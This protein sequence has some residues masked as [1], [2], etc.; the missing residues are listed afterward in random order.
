MPKNISIK[1]KLLSA[2]CLTAL[3]GLFLL[4]TAVI[5]MER[6]NATHNLINELSTM[7]DVVAW[8]SS[9]AMMFDDEKG[10]GE[11]LGSLS[12]KPEIAFACLFDTRGKKYRDYTRP[13]NLPANP[14]EGFLEGLPEGTSITERLKVEGSIVDRN[15]RYIRV[16]RPV[17][18]NDMLLGSIL[19]VDD[20]TQLHDLLRRY[21]ILLA[22]AV[23]TTL[24]VVFIVS[25]W[26]Q[27]L[28]T[29]PMTR[30]IRTMAT[31]TRDKVYEIRAEKQNDDEFGELFD[32]FNEMIR[33]VRARDR[34][35]KAHSAGLEKRVEQRT[36][37]LS[38]A[39]PSWRQAWPS[40]RSQ[41]MRR[42][43][44]AGPNPS[45]WPI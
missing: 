20:L 4:S 7:A 33:E 24:V 19:L 29:A 13:G 35:L 45:F 27:R 1:I 39:K 28:F 26:S 16:I 22:I 3:L 21:S 14:E 15:A 31:V 38:L 5:I 9:V 43:K 34:E 37:D 18:D 17:F 44:P 30:L 12:R 10:A 42:R 25:S 40:L 6:K 2:F 32:H 23:F 11:A 41:G 36:R 8:N